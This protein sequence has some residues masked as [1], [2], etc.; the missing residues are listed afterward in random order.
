ML[1]NS[2]SRRVHLYSIQEEDHQHFQQETKFF[3]SSFTFNTIS[4]TFSLVQFSKLQSPQPLIFE[5]IFRDRWFYDFLSPQLSLM[6]PDQRL[7]NCVTIFGKSFTFVVDGSE[8]PVPSSSHHFCNGEFY[9]VKKG[10]PT[11]NIL[12]VIH[13]ETKHIL[14]LSESCPGSQNDNEIVWKTRGKWIDQFSQQE[15]GLRG[16]GFNGISDLRI[17]T[18]GINEEFNNLMKKFRIR[19]ENVIETCKNFAALKN[20]LRVPP[21][22]QT[23]KLLST[24]QQNW[25]IGAVLVNYFCK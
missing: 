17:V 20:Q 6:T 18:N 10:K 19:V 22:P 16:E 3:C 1:R 4:L 13:I 2:L 9:S 25:V 5:I 24:H 21:A 8:Q 12:I 7:A 14:F 23:G 11:V 15:Y